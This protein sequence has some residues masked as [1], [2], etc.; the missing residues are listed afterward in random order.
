MLRSVEWLSFTDVSGQRFGP[1]LNGQEILDFSTLE[2]ETDSL[3]RNVGKDYHSTLRNIPEERR[4]LTVSC[5]VTSPWWHFENRA[6]SEYLYKYI[7]WRN[8]F[9]IQAGHC[10]DVGHSRVKEE[11]T[12]F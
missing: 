10:A 7:L 9:S 5:F 6:E 8:V 1:I 11:H 4:S 3:S 12:S 2:D